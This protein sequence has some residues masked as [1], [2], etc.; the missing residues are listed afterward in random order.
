[1]VEGSFNG[2]IRGSMNATILSGEATSLEESPSGGTP[3]DT[4][5]GTNNDIEHN[6]KGSVSHE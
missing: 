1:M 3:A 5:P 4:A 2:I 6:E